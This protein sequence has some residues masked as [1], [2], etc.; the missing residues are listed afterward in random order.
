MGNINLKNVYSN[1]SCNNQ[2][3]YLETEANTIK[4]EKDKAR[5][6]QIKQKRH[7]KNNNEFFKILYKKKENR[8][9][10]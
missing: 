3:T 10:S 5:I 8:R 7:V 9:S 2:T 6:T 4:A 1:C